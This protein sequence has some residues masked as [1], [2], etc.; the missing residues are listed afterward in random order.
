M[1]EDEPV[2]LP[3]G[4]VAI[5][6]DDPAALHNAIADAVGEPEAKLTQG[7]STVEQGAHNPEVAGSTPAPATKPSK[8]NRR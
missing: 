8:W 3:E 4:V 5:G 6:L 1:G 7:S 2:P